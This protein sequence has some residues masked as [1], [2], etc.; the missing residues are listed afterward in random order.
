MTAMKCSG[1]RQNRDLREAAQK[2][3]AESKRRAKTARTPIAKVV[4]KQVVEAKDRAYSG[5]AARATAAQMRRGTPQAKSGTKA[6][7]PKKPKRAA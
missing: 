2:D 3:L 6:R 4:T 7:A 5:Q 1:A